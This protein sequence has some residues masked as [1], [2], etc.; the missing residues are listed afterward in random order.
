MRGG[1]SQ[2]RVL[3]LA[4]TDRVHFAGEASH[5]G[6]QSSVSGVHLEEVRAARDVIDQLL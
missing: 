1:Y 3:G 2:R 5:V 6:R 4:H